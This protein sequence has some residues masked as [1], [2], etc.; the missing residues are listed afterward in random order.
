[1]FYSIYSLRK[2]PL[3]AWPTIPLAGHQAT[4]ANTA[5]TQAL[6]PCLLWSCTYSLAT[7]E[8]RNLQGKK[9]TLWVSLYLKFRTQSISFFSQVHHHCPSARTL[10]SSSSLMWSSMTFTLLFLNFSDLSHPLPVEFVNTGLLKVQLSH[11]NY[12]WTTEQPLF[13]ATWNLAEY[14]SYN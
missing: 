5:I 11:Q 12:N 1:M 13:R 3:R 10:V 6:A 8:L 4:S 2:A 7:N 9:H 14:W